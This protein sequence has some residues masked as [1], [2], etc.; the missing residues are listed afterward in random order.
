MTES[1]LQE[2]SWDDAITLASPHPYVLGVTQDAA[3]KPNAIGLCWWTICSWEPPMM[4][5]SVG[6]PRYSRQCLA[7]CREFV[8]CLFGEEH[9]R[10]AWVCG[11]KSG[12]KIDKL[13]QA[14]FTVIPSLKVKVPTIA[15]SV[16]SL[17]C[18]V[19]KEIETGDHILYVGEVVAVRGVPGTPKHLYSQ[20]YRKLIAIGA[21]GAVSLGLA[22]KK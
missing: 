18:R 1:A 6:K 2:M 20:H 9:A 19:A 4:A 22:H 10:G 17:E 15:Q 16:L 13:A 3:G 11:S 12:R 21:D 8:L 7:A 14:G 5:I